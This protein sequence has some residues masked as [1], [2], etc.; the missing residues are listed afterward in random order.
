MKTLKTTL[1]STALLAVI[2]VPAIAAEGKKTKEIKELVGYNVTEKT[3]YQG[4]KKATFMKIDRN[5]DGFVTSKE[6]MAKSNSENAY[7]DFLRMDKSGDKKVTLNEFASFSKTKGSTHFESELHGK[8]AVRGTNLKTRI[9]EEKTY[10]EAVE[11][12]IVEIK[13]I[14]PA[15]E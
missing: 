11:P 6:F 3:E 15:S 10:Y 13:D 2:A 12:T 7:E 9:I 4:A 5:K 14:Q 8:T 1:L